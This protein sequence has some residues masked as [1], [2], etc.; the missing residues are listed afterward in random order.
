MNNKKSEK[1]E[2]KKLKHKQTWLE[3]G[4]MNLNF[5]TLQVPFHVSYKGS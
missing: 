5:Q 4:Q 2:A 1:R 3:V